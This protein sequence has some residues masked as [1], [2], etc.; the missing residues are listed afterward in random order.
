MEEHTPEIEGV[1]IVLV[2][3]FNP[4]ILHPS[5]LAARGLIRAE[6]A[7]EEAI[8]ADMLVSRQLTTFRLSWLQLQV[9][10]DR[11]V[12]ETSDPSHFATLQELVLGV[13]HDLEFTPISLMGLNH[14]M[15]FSM[16]TEEEGHAL[17]DALAPKERWLSLFDGPQRDRAP[18]LRTLVVEGKRPAASSKITRVK[19]EPSARIVPGV[20]IETNDHYESTLKDSPAEAMSWLRECWS[21]VRSFSRSVGEQILSGEPE[22]GTR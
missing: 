10:D 4:A 2:G 20:F 7:S 11:F 9:T 1:Q 15:H 21:E 6:E 12:A 18:G 14:H 16:A 17:G 22:Q 13:F 5:W 3:S 19:V 8:G